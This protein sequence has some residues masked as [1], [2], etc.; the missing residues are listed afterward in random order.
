MHVSCWVSNNNLTSSRVCV[1]TSTLHFSSSRFKCLT[2][3]W[4]YLAMWLVCCRNGFDM[5]SWN[6][7]ER[8]PKHPPIVAND[9]A[10]NHRNIGKWP[11]A[12]H[13]LSQYLGPSTAWVIFGGHLPRGFVG[14]FLGHLPIC[15]TLLNPLCKRPGI[16]PTSDL[17]VWLDTG[18]KH[19]DNL[20][21]DPTTD[22]KASWLQK[23][24]PKAAGR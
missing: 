20:F 1:G 22:L 18:I 3:T 12:D 14:Q 9:R 6:V 5:K 11:C 15:S 4:H 2:W 13:P 7:P 8:V 24:M 19:L 16:S 17:S 23:F 21:L 10:E